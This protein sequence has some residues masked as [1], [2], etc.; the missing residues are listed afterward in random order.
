MLG[1]IAVP[2]HPIARPVRGAA[3]MVEGKNEVFAL[4]R[5][6]NLRTDLM[7]NAFAPQPTRDCTP[8]DRIGPGRHMQDPGGVTPTPSQSQ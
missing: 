3:R 5:R 4:S 8:L 7:I 6:R 1:A 2:Y